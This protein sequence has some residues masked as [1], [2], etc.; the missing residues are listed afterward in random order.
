[1]ILMTMMMMMMQ[2]CV[3]QFFEQFVD[4]VEVDFSFL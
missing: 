4:V 1:V 3:S 2:S